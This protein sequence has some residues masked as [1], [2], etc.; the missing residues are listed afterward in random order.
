MDRPA[1]S[2]RFDVDCP[3]CARITVTH[4]DPME[5]LRIVLAQS[6]WHPYRKITITPLWED[7]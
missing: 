4:T 6:P 1:D 5:G 2:F 7:D 3:Q